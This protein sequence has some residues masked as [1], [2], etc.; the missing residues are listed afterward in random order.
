L[1]PGAKRG[2]VLTLPAGWEPGWT[3]SERPAGKPVTTTNPKP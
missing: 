3:F 1:H 2:P